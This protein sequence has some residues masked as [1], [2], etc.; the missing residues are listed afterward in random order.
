VGIKVFEFIRRADGVEVED[1]ERAWREHA[2]RIAGT[3]DLTRH[4]ERL[5]LNHRLPEDRGRPRHTLEVADAGFDGVAVSW[6]ATLD[7]CQALHAEPEFV[8]LTA[9][10]ERFLRPS[11]VSVIT[12]D[13][14]VIVDKPG[15]D[16]AGAKLLCILRHRDGLRLDEFHEHWLRVHGSLFQDIPELNDPLLGYDQNHGIDLPGAPFDGVTEQWFASL[17]AHVRSLDAPAHRSVVEPDVAS[18][19][20]PPSIHFIMAG[21]PTVAIGA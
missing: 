15:R 21:R 17:D 13:P 5:E 4:I 10:A 2:H 1:F 20:D 7:A 3:P 8:R 11:S 14:E 18:F 19:L 12:R 9:A 6:F 16:R